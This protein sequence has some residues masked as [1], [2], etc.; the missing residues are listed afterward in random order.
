MFGTE[1]NLIIFE[2]F[3]YFLLYIIDKFFTKWNLLF[4]FEA[5]TSVNN[6]RGKFS[7][8]FDVGF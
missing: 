3:D 4:K 1:K 8:L 7:N 5:V 2:R 6:L